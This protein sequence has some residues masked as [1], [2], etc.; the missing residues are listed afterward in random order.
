MGNEYKVVKINGKC[1]Y[2]HRLILEKSLGRKLT[3]NE[4]V[5]HINGNPRDNRIENLE[6]I[7]RSAHSTKY[8][9][10]VEHIKLICPICEKTFYKKP[11]QYRWNMKVGKGILF[12]SYVCCGKYYNKLRQN[13][14][15]E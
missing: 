12:C 3:S 7:S 11:N 6:I 5:H 10:R 13:D 15:I 1:Y 14:L 9:K 2:S 8:A 4:T